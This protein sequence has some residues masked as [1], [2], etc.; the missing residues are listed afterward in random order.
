[1]EK[2][3]QNKNIIITGAGRGIGR[4]IAVQCAK[5]GGRIAAVSR[6]QKE[7][8]ETLEIVKEYSHDSFSLVTDITKKDDVKKLFDKIKDR[9]LTI[10][11]L[12]NN[13]GI[14]S[15][16]GSF[17]QNDL[18]EWEMNINTNLMGTVY[19]TY[20]A[21]KVM[22][23][24]HRGTIINL[25]GG[26]STGIRPNFSAYAVAKTAVVKFTETI[27]AELFDYDIFVN[28]IS[29]GAINTKMLDEVLAL[30][31]KSGSEYLD[32]LK[33]KERGGDDPHLAADLVCFLIS[34]N[35]KGITGKLISAKWDP[36]R[37]ET[38][39]SLLRNDKDAASL[40]RIDNKNF[41]RKT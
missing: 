8:D 14:Q 17:D 6:T 41:Y 2:L 30:K 18:N 5:E 16:I 10:D 9:F 33:R 25:S 32:A 12:V 24:L 38:F 26:G 36:W 13:A 3:L 22:I 15:P 31:G 7:L 40:R 28:T 37:E 4:E 19:C 21:I 23:P 34:E 11:S 20:E 39:R 27:A 35:A 29:P 1:M